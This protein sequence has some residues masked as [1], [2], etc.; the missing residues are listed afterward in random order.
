ME[1]EW[2]SGWLPPPTALVR[3]WRACRRELWATQA[4]APLA[5][6]KV[7]AAD[8]PRLRRAAAALATGQLVQTDWSLNLTE[9]INR[10]AAEAE[11]ASD[12][13]GRRPES[14]AG[15]LRQLPFHRRIVISEAALIAEYDAHHLIVCSD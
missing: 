1:D 2:R 6:A 14:G 10:C 13:E 3:A 15:T 5:S 8:D 4:N 9:V 11:V 12:Y 7:I